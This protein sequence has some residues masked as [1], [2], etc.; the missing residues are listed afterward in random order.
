MNIVFVAAE[1]AP[2]SKAGGLADVA[3]SLPQALAP[4]VDSVQILTPLYGQIDR[5]KHG[6]RPTSIKGEITLGEEV[7]PYALH[8]ST[9]KDG[10]TQIGFISC[11]RFFSTRWYLYRF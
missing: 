7:I 9:D 6:I 1:V 2:Y 10:L 11:D 5:V 3:G 4:Y 8:Q